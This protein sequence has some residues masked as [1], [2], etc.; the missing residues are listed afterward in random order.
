MLRGQQGCG[1]SP[2]GRDL[3]TW[4]TEGLPREDRSLGNGH[5]FWVRLQRTGTTCSQ[6]TSAKAET[7]VL[8]G[9]PRGTKARTQ[10]ARCWLWAQRVAS[11]P[12]GSRGALRS[13]R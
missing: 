1:P 4:S 11:G 2:W 3:Y 9:K 5:W 12:Q 8:K 7:V 13:A 10:A 6:A